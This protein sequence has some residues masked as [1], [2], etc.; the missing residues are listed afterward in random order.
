[1]TPPLNLS[2]NES[3]AG[4]AALVIARTDRELEWSTLAFILAAILIGILCLA[5]GAVL[6]RRRRREDAR[7]LIKTVAID[8]FASVPTGGIDAP[9]HR[10][11]NG[12]VV[13]PT[14]APGPSHSIPEERGKRRLGF[15]ALPQIIESDASRPVQ[16]AKRPTPAGGRSSCGS[17]WTTLPPQADSSSASTLDPFAASLGQSYQ[18]RIQ[19]PPSPLISGDKRSSRGPVSSCPGGPMTPSPRAPM[20]PSPRGSMTPASKRSSVPAGSARN[21]PAGGKDRFAEAFKCVD[22][23]SSENV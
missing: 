13:R 19:P 12:R 14:P 11:R 16:K 17:S 21:R 9:S 22:G 18:L 2:A 5:V 3:V 23:L 15:P 8:P 4:D 6:G 20:T 1:M 7:P 10:S